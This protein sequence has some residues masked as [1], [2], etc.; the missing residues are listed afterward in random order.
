MNKNPLY[1]AV[2]AA[3]VAL[4]VMLMLV[5]WIISTAAPATGVNS[6]LS[7]EGIRWFVG[8][9]TDNVCQP[10]LLWI[11]LLCMAAGALRECRLRECRLSSLRTRYALLM[12][13][14][15][16]LVF[17]VVVVLLTCVPHAI[18]LSSSGSLWHSSFSRGIV[19]MV[20]LAVIV[21]AIVFGV[22]SGIMRSLDDVCRALT[23]SVPVM[24]PLLL[25]YILA[26]QLYYSL[27]FVFG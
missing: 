2:V 12:A 7:G 24:C 26:A 18:L 10:P 4:Q 13:A 27:I 8:R 19:P 5:S 17:I 22:C 6:L 11:V 1:S 16:L 23:R 25:L 9:F 3:L 15:A 21:A 20:A 14:L